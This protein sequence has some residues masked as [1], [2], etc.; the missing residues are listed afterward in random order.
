MREHTMNRKLLTLALLGLIG[1]AQ[2]S[3]AS[4]SG[5]RG[6]SSTAGY[7]PRSYDDSYME[8]VSSTP[9]LTMD[10]RSQA[11]SRSYEADSTVNQ[12]YPLS[13]YQNAQ[14]VNTLRLDGYTLLSY[15]ISDDTSIGDSSFSRTKAV[16]DK[17]PDVSQL[18]GFECT[19]LGWAIEYD[20]LTAVQML[21][22]AG[23]D[24]NQL[25]SGHTPLY[26]A[27]LNLNDPQ[28][29]P[30][31]KASIQRI[32]VYLVAQGAYDDSISG[33]VAASSVA[34]SDDA[35]LDAAIAASQTPSSLGLGSDD[36]N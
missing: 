28:N 30:R 8:T 26:W 11:L 14:N 21:V 13:Y 9:L 16:L 24:V 7:Y 3:F 29:T 6:P 20:S 22:A 35:D 32:I 36:D 1:S 34:T 15:A 4:G 33:P 31:Q 2:E 25:T 27:N 23:A 19:A 17:A 12:E 5:Y 18:D 10:Q